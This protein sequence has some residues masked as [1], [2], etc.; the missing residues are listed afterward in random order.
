[1]IFR[2]LLRRNRQRLDKG[3]L[4]PEDYRKMVESDGYDWIFQMSEWRAFRHLYF[5]MSIVRE[6]SPQ[7]LSELEQM[8]RRVL[9][10]A[11]EKGKHDKD[12]SA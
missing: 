1:M 3:L 7:V 12:G 10:E 2:Y 9:A 5:P 4:L 8:T 6:A 11:E